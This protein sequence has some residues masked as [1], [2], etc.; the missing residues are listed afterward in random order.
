MLTISII[1][2]FWKKVKVDSK[3]NCWLWTASTSRGYGQLSNGRN[4]KP[5]K[6]HRLSWEIHYGEIPKGLE[7][8]HKCDNRACVN[9]N[10]LFIGTHKEN[11]ID[12]VKKKRLNNYTHGLGPENNA[13]ILSWDD[14]T[15]IRD[16]FTKGATLEE[17]IQKYHHTNIVRI[18]RNKVY[19]DPKYIPINGNA[20]PRPFRRI[21]SLQ[22]REK[23]FLDIGSSRT[24]AKKYGVSRPVILKIKKGE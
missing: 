8:C 12:A 23:V 5:Y 11:I 24:L 7:I 13:A 1:D 17:L 16:A 22:E 21:L 9:P 19:Y 4:K 15:K 10:H 2:R 14:I 20:R 3:N 6:T 18:V